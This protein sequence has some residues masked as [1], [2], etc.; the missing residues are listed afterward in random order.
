VLA[1]DQAVEL[2]G[3]T[4]AESYLSEKLLL[5]AAADTGAGAIHPGYGFLAESA[6]FARSVGDSNLTFIGP[7]PAAIEEM[8]DKPRARAR[9]VAAGVPVVPGSCE[10]SSIASAREAAEEVGF[11]VMIKAAGGGGGKG[12]HVVQDPAD[13]AVAFE[14]AQR[15]AEG[16]FG[17]GRIYLEQ[18]L[19]RPR[20]IEIQILADEHR[21]LHLG[22]RE[23]SIQRRHQKL[24][25]E[26]PA[27]CVD[28]ALRE[29]LGAVAVR[30]AEAVG[31]LGAGTVEFLL[32]GSD[33]FFL[34][35]NTRIQ[36]EH[37]VTE[38]V[39]GVDLVREQL[40]IA[41]GYPALD[42]SDAPSPRG[43]A[44][45]CRIS[46]EDPQK[47]FLPSVGRVESLEIPMGPGI[48][49]DG[50][51]RVG[52]EVGLHYDPLLGKLIVHAENRARAIERMQ[53]ALEELWVDGLETTQAY[54]LS[55]LGEEDFRE[56]DLSI[57]YVREHPE[58]LRS[59]DPNLRKVAIATA[60]LCENHLDREVSAGAI[61][62]K[63]VVGQ[64]LSPWM[65]AGREW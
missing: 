15:E 13:L 3:A 18:F 28:Q 61:K 1:A 44:L 11:P 48:R 39:T 53:V 22:E 32:K 58:L 63:K 37:P 42:G 60:V 4:P 24:I 20:H 33:F 45:E 47:D 14:R 19:L 6:K 9:M 27:P 26:A 36:V 34:E 5:K 31:Y 25:E 29:K 52:F 23:C 64:R 62:D 7:P 49:W 8:G 40:R 21:T 35:M 56:G 59:V 30:A 16:A 50:G 12:M 10:L 41:L 51:I 17:D 55:V 46:A 65:Q 57:E 2:G 43:H 54:H 38:M